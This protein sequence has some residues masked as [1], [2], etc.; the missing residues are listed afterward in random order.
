[1]PLEGALAF[2]MVAAAL[3][4]YVAGAAPGLT[5][6]HQGADGGELVTAALVNGVPH[7]PGYP[8]YILLLQGWLRLTQAIWPA[9]DLIWQAALF[10]CLCA[11][12][13]VGVTLR[14]ARHL[15]RGARHPLLWSAVAAAAWAI[16][17]LLWTQA[18]IAEVYSLHALLLALLGW[19]VL[20]HPAKLWYV[21]IVVALGV[22]NHLTT[23]LLLPAAAY[24]LWQGRRLQL[25]LPRSDV[26]RIAL[27]LGGG[28]VLG[29]ML[30]I[31]IP[32]AARGAAPVNWGYADNWQ[33]F[34]WLV[35]G[36]AYRGYLFA[37]MPGALLQRLAAWAYAITS[38]YTALG[39]A[40]ALWG[41][42]YWDRTA[43]YLRNFSLL[44]LLPVSLYAIAYNTRDSD[45]YLLPVGW[46]M[47]LWLAVGLVQFDGWIARHLPQPRWGQYAASTVLSAALVVVMLVGL[48]M[49]RW[50]GTALASDYEARDYLAQVESVLE[51]GSILVTLEDRETFAVWYGVW[52]SKELAMRVPGIVPVNDSLYQFDWYRRLQGVL[53]PGIPGIDE[54]ID[55]LV[56]A[57]RSVRPIYY[58]QLPANL[59]ESELT[60]AGPL[61]RLKE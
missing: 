55:A 27:A 7:P 33:G 3:A 26:W 56:A 45:I 61:W 5:W 13:S 38:Q 39:L 54:S 20:V 31:R 25:A 48:G 59:A 50:P 46:L 60:P 12:L 4:V 2:G 1:M 10:S 16:S 11:A 57:N 47:A 15:L 36:A 6:A 43:G 44:W 37:A 9:S 17:P 14:T 28:L 53:Y 52:G 42:A 18:V 8:L 32:L 58:A 30:Y 35:S 19:A 21:I 49:W 24:A 29:A 41:L 22:A 51:P 34:W 40:L 23:V